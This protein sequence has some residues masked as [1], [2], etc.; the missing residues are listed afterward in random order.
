MDRQFYLES[1]IYKYYTLKCQV[2]ADVVDQLRNLQDGTSDE[3]CFDNRNVTTGGV[4]FE[5]QGDPV[6]VAR[7]F[8]VSHLY[9]DI[10]CM[11]IIHK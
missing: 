8:F 2:H 7:P 1:H 10:C 9:I 6:A 4:V 11:K 5:T 3:C